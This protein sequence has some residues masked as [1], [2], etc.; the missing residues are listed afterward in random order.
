MVADLEETTVDEMTNEG[1][2]GPEGPGEP[3]ILTEEQHALLVT[4]LCAVL[5][6]DPSGSAEVLFSAEDF[7]Q[8]IVDAP[9][10]FF[11][12]ADVMMA[13]PAEWEER[14]REHLLSRKPEAAQ[15]EPEPVASP[16]P[17]PPGR[18]GGDFGS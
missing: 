1:S 18:I 15:P 17:P 11:E 5:C 14:F 3:E 9:E 4:A 8:R 16:P 7:V 13:P 2:R 10:K 6:I 12:F